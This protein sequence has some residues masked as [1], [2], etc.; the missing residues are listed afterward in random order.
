MCT[1]RSN[2]LTRQLYY[3]YSADASGNIYLSTYYD[4]AC[5][6]PTTALYVKQTVQKCVGGRYSQFLY[7]AQPPDSFIKV[8]T[9]LPAGA[10]L[11]RTIQY[12]P[13]DTTCAN[14]PVYL[15]TTPVNGCTLLAAVGPGNLG[16]AQY[17]ADNSGTLYYKQFTGTTTC[18]PSKGLTITNLFD[19]QS[20]VTTCAATAAGPRSQ[21]WKVIPPLPS[22]LTS[23]ITSTVR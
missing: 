21:P 8:N 6:L 13:G 1:P 11:L 7:S 12:S 4:T 10:V 14:T 18:A 23:M 17:I 9:T 19:T 16:S 3:I 2:D 22:T 5:T 20:V 15:T